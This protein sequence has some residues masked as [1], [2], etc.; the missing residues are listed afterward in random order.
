[1]LSVSACIQRK[2][3]MGDPYLRLPLVPPDICLRMKSSYRLKL[4]RKR[5]SS[6]DVSRRGRWFDL[7]PSDGRETKAGRGIAAEHPASR[8][9]M[10][11]KR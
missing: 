7:R 8:S 3:I 4:G 11:R 9:L 10:P 1:M 6:L 2:Y 5:T